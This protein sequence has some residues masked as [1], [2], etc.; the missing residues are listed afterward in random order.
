M[1]GYRTGYFQFYGVSGTKFSSLTAQI[2]DHEQA[3][4]DSFLV[5][6]KQRELV[7]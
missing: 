2:T 5:I 6:W 1:A 4:D 3:L 7:E